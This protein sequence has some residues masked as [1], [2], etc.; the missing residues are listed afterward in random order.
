[1]VGKRGKGMYGK[2]NGVGLLCCVIFYLNGIEFWPRFNILGHHVDILCQSPRLMRYPSRSSELLRRSLDLL[3]V[4]NLKR[5][6]GFFFLAFKM[7]MST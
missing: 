3:R 1:M 5:R 7:T 6:S 2:P 4:V